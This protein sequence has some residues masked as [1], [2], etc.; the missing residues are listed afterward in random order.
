MAAPMSSVKLVTK[1]LLLCFSMNYAL[2]QNNEQMQMQVQEVSGFISAPT[3]MLDAGD[4]SGRKFICEAS[5]AIRIM[6]NDLIL[7]QDLLNIRGEKQA[8][9]QLLGMAFHPQHKINGKFYV[10]YQEPMTNGTAV[11]N[12]QKVLEAFKL[13]SLDSQLKVKSEGI[14]LKITGCSQTS[15]GNCIVFGKDG[16]LYLAIGDEQNALC[17]ASTNNCPSK[18]LKNFN[19]KILRI[20]LNNSGNGYTS[21]NDNPFFNNPAALPEVYAS[22]LSNP[23]WFSLDKKNGYIY[24]TDQPCDNLHNVY[25]LERG[26][27]FSSSVKGEKGKSL[28]NPV[29]QFTVGK[30]NHVIG[31][32]IYHGSKF[33]KLEGKYV[34]GDATGNLFFLNQNSDEETVGN[35]W[36]MEQ[37]AVQGDA[38]NSI[39]YNINSFGI[40][41]AGELYVLAS[42][43]KEAGKS[44]ILFKVI[45][46]K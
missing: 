26:R 13:S 34:F 28:L 11:N 16:Y 8:K 23:G 25:I 4:G 18:N 12:M 42:G 43:N 27:D 39:P 38:F 9:R 7:S 21:P 10:F 37:I 33:P 15:K 5:G 20:S 31:G 17:D 40:D 44:G 2:A 41:S 36:D 6:E 29:A 32:Y 3:S 14:V 19:G 46:A 35:S 1:C 30:E 24:F 45:Q 22:G